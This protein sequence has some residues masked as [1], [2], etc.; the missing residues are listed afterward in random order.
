M[1][2][3][4]QLA[5]ARRLFY[6]AKTWRLKCDTAST[7]ADLHRTSC[8]AGLRGGPFAGGRSSRHAPLGAPAPQA[9]APLLD[10]VEAQVILQMVSVQTASLTARDEANGAGVGCSRLFSGGNSL[11]RSYG[12]Q[13]PRDP[14][15]PERRPANA[16]E[17]PRKRLLRCASLLPWRKST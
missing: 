13:G 6:T 7:G 5:F 8:G 11:F 3:I 9:S 4:S 10:G 15:M 2:T 1:G 12:P 16:R 14:H 17:T